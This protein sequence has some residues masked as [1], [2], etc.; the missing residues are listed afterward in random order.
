[1]MFIL[2]RLMN[3]K[4]RHKKKKE[5][6]HVDRQIASP[7]EQFVRSVALTRRYRMT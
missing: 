1:M 4:G 2:I 3:A 7:K 5:R 6:R